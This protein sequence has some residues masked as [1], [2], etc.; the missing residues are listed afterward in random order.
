M[1]FTLNLIVRH[2]ASI[3]Q[4]AATI[5]HAATPVWT[6]VTNTNKLGNRVT[7]NSQILLWN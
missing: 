3:S 4:L 7:K 5:C 2:G 1:E 6:T